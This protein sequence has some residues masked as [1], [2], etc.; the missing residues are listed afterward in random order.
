MKKIIAGFTLINLIMAIVNVSVIVA[1]ARPIAFMLGF[2]L[3]IVL[4][5]MMSMKGLFDRIKSSFCRLVN[6]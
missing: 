5:I 6:R 4:I 1:F 3:I 2:T